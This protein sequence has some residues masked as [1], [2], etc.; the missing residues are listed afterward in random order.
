MHLRNTGRKKVSDVHI[1][2]GAD[3]H[4]ALISL[5]SPP[6][7]LRGYPQRVYTTHKYISIIDIKKEDNF[8]VIL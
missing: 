6:P 4:R 7:S 3:L 5:L 8:Y 1:R 2:D